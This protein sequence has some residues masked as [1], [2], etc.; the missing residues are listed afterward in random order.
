MGVLLAIVLIWRNRR[1]VLGPVAAGAAACVLVIAPWTIRNWIVFDTPVFL[2]QQSAENLA[3]AN[4]HATYYGADIGSWRFDCLT[5]RAPGEP[6]PRWADALRKKGLDY[7]RDHAGRVPVVLAA[8][9]SRTWG[10]RAPSQGFGF[11]RS[12]AWRE[13]VIAWIV[14]VLGAV[15]ALV[16]RRRGVPIG[17]L[18]VPAVT[19]TVAAL[20]QFGL[21]RYR[22]SADLAL[23]VLGAFALDAAAA[24]MRSRR[25]E[26]TRSAEAPD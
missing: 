8:R 13:S 2:S 23:L 7:A 4:C 10:L 25:R 1:A 20:V 24:E 26:A 16:A 12:E 3:G 18:L 17:I 21:L 14:L 5:P 19:V 11:T 6:E 9:V 15:G 22:Y